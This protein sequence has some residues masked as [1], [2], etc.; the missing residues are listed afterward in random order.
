MDVNKDSW[1]QMEKVQA[2]NVGSSLICSLKCAADAKCGAS[3]Y[4]NST[5]I[6]EM[7]NVR[8]HLKYI[9]EISELFRC[10]VYK[11]SEMKKTQLK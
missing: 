10:C 5:K 9:L 11:K 7:A 1:H 6:C 3:L 2:T 8:P 4:N